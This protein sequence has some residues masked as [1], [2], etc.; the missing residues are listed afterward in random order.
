MKTNQ[1]NY[2]EYE[3]NINNGNLVGAGGFSYFKFENLNNNT[4]VAE[5]AINFEYKR[6]WELAPIQE[7][8]VNVTLA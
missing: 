4:K 1:T 7:F 5:V 8:T 2:G 3:E 6:T